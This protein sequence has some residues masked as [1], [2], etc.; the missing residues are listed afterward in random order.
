MKSHLQSFKQGLLHSKCSVI[1]INIMPLLFY[2]TSQKFISSFV[3]ELTHAWT[4]LL[5]LSCTFLGLF[6]ISSISLQ[7]RKLENQ[8]VHLIGH[9]SGLSL[10]KGGALGGMGAHG[11]CSKHESRRRHH[12]LQRHMLPQVDHHIEEGGVFLTKRYKQTWQS[13][14]SPWLRGSRKPLQ[15]ALENPS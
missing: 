9:L 4:N 6:S 7:R 3:G 15:V 2:E 14:H 8:T 1:L 11:L 13:H 12:Y 10:P 5:F